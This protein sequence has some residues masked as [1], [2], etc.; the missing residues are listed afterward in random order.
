MQV[1]DGLEEAYKAAHREIWPEIL[2]GIAKAKIKNYSIFMLGTSLFSYFEVE[3][4]DKAITML[5]A[6]SDNRRWQEYMAHMFD[7]GP[8]IREGTTLYLEEVFHL[9]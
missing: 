7:V 5:A 6:D 1:K 4:L 3:D 9:D 2:T 8:G